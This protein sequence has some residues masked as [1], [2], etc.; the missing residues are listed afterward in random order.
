MRGKKLVLSLIVLVLVVAAGAAG[1]LFFKPHR[2]IDR[3]SLIRVNADSLYLSFQADEAAANQR[4]LDKA[5]EITGTISALQTN[6]QGQT[7]VLLDTGDL[8][9]AVACTLKTP[10]KDAANGKTVVV[11]GFCSGYLSDVVIRDAEIVP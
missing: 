2:S 6:Q 10:V 8:M 3:S 9:G 5:L 1:Y 11:R 4:Y 7:V